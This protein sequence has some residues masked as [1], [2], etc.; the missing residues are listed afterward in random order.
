MRVAGRT[1]AGAGLRILLPVAVPVRL[2]ERSAARDRGRG[3]R[4]D[5]AAPAS[6][7]SYRWGG[8]GGGGLDRR[9]GGGRR[10]QARRPHLAGSFRAGALGA[11]VS[12][13]GRRLAHDIAHGLC[14]IAF[15][16][17]AL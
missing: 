6:T 14:P 16:T 3:W 12:C 10:G 4:H 8:G 7:G 17:M 15:L 5:A 9:W 11:I 13:N 2:G 1:R